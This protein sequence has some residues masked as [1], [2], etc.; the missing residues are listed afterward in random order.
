MIRIDST[1]QFKKHIRSSILPNIMKGYRILLASFLISIALFFAFSKDT[2]PIN[3]VIIMILYMAIFTV[4]TNI[5]RRQLISNFEDW[6]GVFIYTFSNMFK[7]WIDAELRS[8]HGNNCCMLSGF[9]TQCN[10]VIALI[11][12][13]N[14]SK[15][16]TAKVLCQIFYLLLKF[17]NY[18]IFDI[19]EVLDITLSLI[20]FAILSYYFQSMKFQ[21]F[22][23]EEK[24]IESMLADLA[25]SISKVSDQFAFI[26]PNDKNKLSVYNNLHSLNAIFEKL[27]AKGKISQIEDVLRE[28]IQVQDHQKKLNENSLSTNMNLEGNLASFIQLNKMWQQENKSFYPES[29]IEKYIIDNIS[30][31]EEPNHFYHIKY[32]YVNLKFLRE[33]EALI[34]V[35]FTKVQSLNPSKCQEPSSYNSEIKAFSNE[36]SNSLRIMNNHIYNLQRQNNV[37]IKQYSR[38]SNFIE[39]SWN[40]DMDCFGQTSSNVQTR[41]TSGGVNNLPDLSITKSLSKFVNSC[42]FNKTQ[43]NSIKY[44][45]KKVKL[46]LNNFYYVYTSFKPTNASLDEFNLNYIL[47][48]CNKSIK[49][50][51]ESKRINLFSNLEE[52]NFYTVKTDSN[53]LKKLIYNIVLMVDNLATH[54]KI[55]LS[56]NVVERRKS[57]KTV[58]VIFKV[59]SD[60]ANSLTNLSESVIIKSLS[61]NQI[62]H[63]SCQCIAKD[64]N[65]KY[66]KVVDNSDNTH[67][68]I[69][70]F[71]KFTDC[72]D[73]FTVPNPLKMNTDEFLL[74]Q[75]FLENKNRSVEIQ[76]RISSLQRKCIDNIPMESCHKELTYDNLLTKQNFQGSSALIGKL[77]SKVKIDMIPDLILNQS[78]KTSHKNNSPC[79]CC[80]VLIVDD[81]ALCINYLSAIVKSY[82]QKAKTA[83]NGQ[84]AYDIVKEI[85]SKNCKTCSKQELIVFMDIHMPIMNGMESAKKIDE[86]IKVSADSRKC[87]LYFIS[88][89]VDSQF[90]GLLNNLSI[91]GGFYSKPIKKKQISDILS[92]K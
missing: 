52:S 69:I 17:Y 54:F 49:F 3:L 27:K 88:G 34:I 12:I 86:L 66:E 83:T 41:F 47:E 53:L 11:L 71:D 57:E 2:V 75:R 44:L 64:I 67:T 78:E 10:N 50:I 62:L 28:F 31:S 58:C 76:S 65:V 59:T 15:E 36:I 8:I 22:E 63:K 32:A 18:S 13:Q 81:D 70:A 89:N 9:L 73:I 61:I 72:R 29:K 33:G 84:I 14:F 4:S 1:T 82:T 25:H 39:S 74:S 16:L 90:S 6:A 40:T 45:R 37:N 79:N 19:Y 7:L 91:C 46:M 60:K 43:M 38:L 35:S 77:D 30:D 87:K 24:N 55:N 68:F 92:N 20:Y 26:T 80:N 85:L 23:L 56:I 42:E 51:S 5:I 48:K 21:I